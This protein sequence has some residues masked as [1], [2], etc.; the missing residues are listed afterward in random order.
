[1]LRIVPPPARSYDL[2]AGPQVGERAED[3]DEPIVAASGLVFSRR[4]LGCEPRE[5]EAVLG[6]LERD[7]LDDFAHLA[8]GMIG[9]DP[10][11]TVA[12]GATLGACA[13]ATETYLTT[14]G[15]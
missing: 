10:T 7:S 9:R 5:R 14:R 8:Q 15:H 4:A 11:G 13:S 12:R 1:M 3:G 2:L 6:V